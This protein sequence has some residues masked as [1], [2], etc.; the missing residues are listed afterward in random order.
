[1]IGRVEFEATARRLS[2][3]YAKNREIAARQMKNSQ[4]FIATDG[5]FPVVPLHRVILGL[6]GLDMLIRNRSGQ[7]LQRYMSDLSN[8]GYVAVRDGD[9]RF[10]AIW[11]DYLS[12]LGHLGASGPS[13]GT[14]SPRAVRVFFVP[15]VRDDPKS[16]V[17]KAMVAVARD[18]LPE[19]FSQPDIWFV[20]D[21][22]TGAMLP[23]KAVWGLA[24]G[25]KGAEFNSHYARDRLRSLGFRVPGPNDPAADLAIT[26]AE[27]ADHPG[28]MEGAVRQVT[29]NVRERNPKARREAEAYYRARNG[30]R[31]QCEGCGIDFGKAYGTRGEGF[32]HFHHLTPLAQSDGPRTIIAATHLV[33]LCPNCHAMVHY[34]E[35]MWDMDDLK[36]NLRRFQ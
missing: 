26:P 35:K 7:E 11:D 20:Q 16:L 9:P 27:L 30:G 15:V 14:P 32:M 17:L 10:E 8:A 28:L 3:L 21:P 4:D 5:H 34:G 36:A 31:L 22:N 12:V 23:A 33:P 2:D 6:R 25:Q 13:N 1:M 18:G 24:T 19:G 29:K